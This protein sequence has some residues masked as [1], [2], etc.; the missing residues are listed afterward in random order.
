M[1]DVDELQMTK[2]WCHCHSEMAKIKYNI[3]EIYTVLHCSNNMYG[4]TIDH[5]INGARNTYMLLTNMIQKE[6]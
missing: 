1:V 2:L 5:D 6:K 3:K 4:I